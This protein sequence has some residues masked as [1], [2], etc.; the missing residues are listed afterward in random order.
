VNRGLSQDISTTQ[1][2]NVIWVK[3]LLIANRFRVIRTLDVAVA[4]FAER[5]FKAALTAAQRATRGMVKAGLLRRYRTNRF[6]TVYGLTQAGVDYLAEAGWD[7]SSSVRRVA[8]MS[9]PEHRLW[10][11]FLVLA[12]EARGIQAQTEQELLQELNKGVKPGE[13]LVAGLLK[14]PHPSAQR[15]GPL[16][17]RPDAVCRDL[18]GTTAFECDIS[19]RGSDREA[20]LA[21]EI[22]SIGRRLAD[23]TRLR[24][25]VVMC[26]TSRIRKRALAVMAS[27]IQAYNPQVLTGGVRHFK[28][29]QDGVYEVW[30]AVE[31]DVP[32]GRICLND[33]LAGYVVIAL[34][35]VWL[36]K[37]RIDSQ[38]RHSM[39]GWL[40]ENYLPYARAHSSPAW[41]ALKSPLM[42]PQ[43]L[44]DQRRQE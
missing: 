26:K 37:V 32:D 1:L 23:G 30:S 5:P 33:H 14:V 42:S 18:E 36:P 44:L 34:L 9:N 13:P 40:D 29:I 38:N 22:L 8:D 43:L 17:L 35:P 41:P 24:R 28:E 20:S 10:T 2:R 27:L 15:K 11:Q 31:Q 12:C 4:C 3:S 19:K 6:Q 21:A 39:A 16:T 25:V 7:A